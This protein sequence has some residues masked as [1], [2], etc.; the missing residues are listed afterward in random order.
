VERVGVKRTF[1]HD[2]LSGMKL[3]FFLLTMAA[4]LA[5]QPLRPVA[6]THAVIIDG[7]GGPAIENGTVLV[8]G[9]RIEAAGPAE[10]VRVP[11]DA[12]VHDLGGKA[13]L[14][15]L[16]DMHVHLVGGWDGETVDVLGY[17][18]YLN[19]LLYSGV[20]T[21]LDAGNYLPFIVQMR[22]EVAAGRLAGPRIYCAG[23]L[24]DGSDPLWRPISYSL[25]SADQAPGI[26]K[27]LKQN[28]VDLLKVYV[29]VSDRLMG[30][31]VREARKNSL[32]V[33]VDQAWRNG[34]IELVMGDGVTMFAHLPDVPVGKY[35]GTDTLQILKQR[36][37]RFTSTLTV[38]ESFSH[39]R[40]SDLSFTESPLVRDTVS[41][42]FVAELRKMAGQEKSERTRTAEERN[43]A[44]FKDRLANA[45]KLFDAG[46]LIAAGTDAPYPGVF[47]GEG[48]HHEL[49]L[50]VE[51]G[52][53]PLEA[54]A[55]ATRNAAQFVSA[56]KEWGTLAAGKLAD[57]LV[58]SGRPDRRIQDTRNIEIVMQRG[59][60]L[61][62]SKLKLDP[63]T[64]PGFQPTAP[65]RSGS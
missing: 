22:D 63:A 37:V 21:V 32:P 33:L 26:V 40:L 15:G 8:R 57:I 28:R 29:G 53:K 64:D 36:E 2:G 43:L 9:E 31:L 25:T 46:I 12:D 47:Q 1:G 59:K 52:L 7:N 11:A 39:R 20:T 44:R 61:D 19:A 42:A 6:F 14:P 18:R 16:A 38:V 5:A 62:R 51:A 65:V 60:I 45:K 41:P 55:A 58:V 54:I 10:S 49:E 56:E 13:I 34:S 23:P 48:L 17:R 27:E 30:A 3:T 50:L 24:I 4:V 35:Y